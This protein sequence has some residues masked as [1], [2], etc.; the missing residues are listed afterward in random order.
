MYIEEKI[1]SEGILTKDHISEIY[2]IYVTLC[3]NTRFKLLP[4]DFSQ[5]FLQSSLSKDLSTTQYFF[6]IDNDGD[7]RINF[8]DFLRFIVLNVK[9]VLGQL[10]T[11]GILSRNLPLC[12][13]LARK[14][15]AFIVSS[16][17]FR[18][19]TSNPF[20]IADLCVN[21]L[22][23]YVSYTH[24]ISKLAAI[25]N[26]SSDI[27]L[28][29]FN[30]MLNAI[31][32]NNFINDISI[33][34]NSFNAISAIISIKKLLKPMSYITSHFIVVKFAAQLMSGLKLIAK[35]GI[36]E[37]L[38]SIVNN[39]TIIPNI[40]IDMIYYVL[41]CLKQL[42][43]VSNFLIDVEAYATR[44]VALM[45][46]ET[47]S[48]ILF[49]KE[50]VET[51]MIPI[52]S[53]RL[54]LLLSSGVEKI[55]F[56]CCLI[57]N[58][59]SKKGV[60]FFK[61]TFSQ[62]R[63]IDIL[64]E[65]TKRFVNSD[66]SFY[67][68]IDIALFLMINISERVLMYDN[69]DKIFSEIVVSLNMILNA[70]ISKFFSISNEM[71][72][73]MILI[74]MGMLSSS[75]YQTSFDDRIFILKFIEMKIIDRSSNHMMIYPF[76]FY[77]KSLL[78]TN[79]SQILPLVSELKIITTFFNYCKENFEFVNNLL[80]I[81]DIVIERQ[82]D[83]LISSNIIREIL[84]IFKEILTAKDVAMMII[85]KISAM[86]LKLSSSKDVI[87]IDLML[88]TNV[89]S[90]LIS[91]V[92]EKWVD[93]GFYVDILPYDKQRFNTTM[94][95]NMLSSLLNIVYSD[96]PKTSNKFSSTFSTAAITSI[97]KIYN[98]LILLWTPKEKA[99]SELNNSQLIFEKYKDVPKQNL[100]ISTIN[101]FEALTYSYTMNK[102]SNVSDELISYLNSSVM[103]MKGKL[104]DVDVEDVMSA[105]PLIK[106]FVQ[107]KEETK[108]KSYSLFEFE[109]E[110]V[111]F[112]TVSS[113]INSSYHSE[114]DFYI[115]INDAFVKV[116]NEEDFG[117]VLEIL[118]EEYN[119]KTT[120][121][122]HIDVIC[123]V[124]EKEK[125]TVVITMCVKCGKKIEVVQNTKG[126]GIVVDQTTPPMCDECQ[127]NVIEEY[128]QYLV[129][130]NS[131]MNRSGINANN[132]M[133][134][135]QMNN[136]SIMT[137]AGP[138]KV[139]SKTTFINK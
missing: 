93:V 73:A 115:Y 66:L 67:N 41:K 130:S 50:Y 37:S 21:S 120:A 81:I 136:N 119:K 91:K 25:K 44:S 137:S 114:M 77:I 129:M 133:M 40:N 65:K 57:V 83:I 117:K 51:K 134:T 99:S 10:F 95:D 17:L 125:K 85:D 97:C 132:T 92:E 49:Y 78:A 61:G 5:I 124:M 107:S 96:I 31:N 74:N 34:L 55:N 90:L 43:Y 123:M 104:R 86:I 64:M 103:S 39:N 3:D 94:L 26:K 138:V 102:Q 35:F 52:L 56:M 32:D 1:L 62:Y 63:Y 101:L 8:Q 4:S 30:M 82:F 69:G 109:S 7:G 106:L 6:Q 110:N 76:Y 18:P 75:N 11:K 68:D 111:S 38:L 131:M 46:K 112:A 139:L 15:F 113:T 29:Q 45:S 24:C 28:S 128:T 121:D 100:L 88:D 58:E 2:T 116:K 108:A 9:T 54:P 87:I 23:L 48:D 12:T 36:F 105:L 98:D 19:S 70:L 22:P 13:Q 60:E 79:K 20:Y 53:S 122:G 33:A 127:R 84:T 47:S 126:N 16:V 71:A 27:K 72:Q 89:I 42:I 80:D 118:F 59:I 135:P 14:N